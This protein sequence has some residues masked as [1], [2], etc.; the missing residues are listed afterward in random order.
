MKVLIIDD[1][2][3]KIANLTELINTLPFKFSIDNTETITNAILLFK[4]NKYD[5]AIID[6]HLPLR[7]GENPNPNGGKLLLEEVYRKKDVLNIPKYILGF[8]QYNEGI[9]D[10][11]AIWKVIKYEPSNSEWKNSILQLFKHVVSL[12]NG[13]SIIEEEVLPTIIVEGLTDLDFINTSI[14]LFFP[15]IKKKLFVKSQSNAGANWVA[16]QIVIWSL[17]NFK[18]TNG[19]NI[20]SIGLLDSD[21]AGSLAKKVIN[22]RLKSQNEQNSFKIIQILPKYN[23]ELL[24]FYKEKCKIE[25]EIESLFPIEILEYADSKN[26]LEYRNQTFISPPSDWEQHSQTSSQY[27][28]SKGISEKQ[29]LYTKKVKLS[30]KM[31]FSKYVLSLDDK[32]NTFRNFKLLIK[33]LILNLEIK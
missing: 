11:S 16:N 9:K 32:N 1:S 19:I 24:K 12:P 15:E 29:L 25:L 8:S 10:F 18:D 4:E 26:W 7:I 22:E 13:N 33:D 31:D 5:V 21:E 2:I 27:I 23:P 6:L 17:Q 30:K 14:E 3:D 20:K 28:I